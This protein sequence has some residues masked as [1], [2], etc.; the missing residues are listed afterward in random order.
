MKR[1]KT[2]AL[3]DK[4]TDSTFRTTWHP[5][6]SFVPESHGKNNGEKNVHD[7][8]IEQPNSTSEAGFGFVLLLFTDSLF[9]FICF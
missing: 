8:A 1:Q 5:L 7:T 4:Q 3:L 6:P 2:V 9:S